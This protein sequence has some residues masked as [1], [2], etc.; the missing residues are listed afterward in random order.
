MQEEKFS[1][2]GGNNSQVDRSEPDDSQELVASESDKD[3]VSLS[4][5]NKPF[6]LDE[7][8]DAS[9]LSENDEKREPIDDQQFE[10]LETD[11]VL[12]KRLHVAPEDDKLT[13]SFKK[14]HKGRRDKVYMQLNEA[15]KSRF[16]AHNEVFGTKI[17]SVIEKFIQDLPGCT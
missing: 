17:V 6:N 13:S 5:S 3:S 9:N 4:K 7:G 15:E 14:F 11:K 8:D 12:G 1:E 10:Q 16:D 2:S